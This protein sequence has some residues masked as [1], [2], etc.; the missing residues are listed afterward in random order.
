EDAN[1]RAQ[2]LV[3]WLC[4]QSFHFFYEDPDTGKLQTQSRGVPQGP[5][6]SAYLANISLFPLDRVLSQIVAE[7]DKQFREKPDS[8]QCG[9]VYARYVDDMVIIAPTADDV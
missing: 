1:T 7:L 5:D 2:A 8:P 6:L 3:D 4:D 9:G